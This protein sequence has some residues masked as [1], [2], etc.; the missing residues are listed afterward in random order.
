MAKWVCSGTL[1]FNLICRIQLCDKQN[2]TVV[3][4]CNKISL[5]SC[6]KT[7][8]IT[9]FKTRLI[10]FYLNSYLM[11]DPMHLHVCDGFDNR[12]GMFIDSMYY[13]TQLLPRAE[14]TTY[15]NENR[16]LSFTVDETHCKVLHIKLHILY[17][18]NLMS[19]VCKCPCCRS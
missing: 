6:W 18:L 2:L 9:F 12:R 7:V 13:I 3:D 16:F 1:L 14:N 11:T 10:K 4:C 5:K 8:L 19:N 17:S 15:W